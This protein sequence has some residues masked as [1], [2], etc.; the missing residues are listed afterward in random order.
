MKVDPTT[1][2]I[3]SLIAPDVNGEIE[4]LARRLFQLDL[5]FQDNDKEW[6]A[7]NVKAEIGNIRWNYRMM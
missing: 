5:W 1:G 4:P 7:W 3:L 6:P 2:A